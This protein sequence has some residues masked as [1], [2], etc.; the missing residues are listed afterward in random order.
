M[1]LQLFRTDPI[2]AHFASIRPRIPDYQFLAKRRLSV[3]RDEKGRV[4]Y[5]GRLFNLYIYDK[6]VVVGI[7]FLASIILNST[8]QCQKIPYIYF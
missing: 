5:Y 4:A 6:S 8:C 2:K 1:P 7:T 3:V